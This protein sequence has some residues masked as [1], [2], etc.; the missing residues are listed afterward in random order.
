M[1]F[2]LIRLI[3]PSVGVRILENGFEKTGGYDYF[4]SFGKLSLKNY[5]ALIVIY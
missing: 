5:D 3:E 1:S 4:T 2:S